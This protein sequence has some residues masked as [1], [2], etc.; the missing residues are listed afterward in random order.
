MTHK[1]NRV[2]CWICRQWQAEKYTERMSF[3][4][5]EETVCLNCIAQ[6]EEREDNLKINAIHKEDHTHEAKD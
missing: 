3:N 2:Q 6:I 4:G 5:M 1:E